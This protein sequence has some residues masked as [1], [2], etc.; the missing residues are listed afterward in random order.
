METR[1]PGHL[2]ACTYVGIYRYCLTFCTDHRRHVFTSNETVNLVLEQI[3][4]AAG[5]NQFAVI[6]YCFMPDH[7]H[8]LIEGQSE[9]SDCRRFI[10]RAKQYSG[11]YYS[12]AF[13]S[14]LWQ[15]YG[16]EHVL[17]DDEETHAVARYI[18]SNPLRAGLA[19]S[20]EDYPYAGSLVCQL[21]ELFEGVAK[22]G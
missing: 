18:L 12:K 17:R 21:R 10:A 2:D 9:S 7:L 22:S 3:S 4:R 6:A 8:L 16:Y 15:R 5:E 11:F 13:D 14:R 1:I 19:E 20:V